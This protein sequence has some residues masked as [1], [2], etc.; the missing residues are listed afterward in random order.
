VQVG[1]NTDGCREIAEML[2]TLIV[3]LAD[4]VK[5]TNNNIN[6]DQIVSGL[7]PYGCSSLVNNKY[8][9]GNA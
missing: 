5:Q 6:T 4:L 9:I 3:A 2:A 1:P 7:L 8:L